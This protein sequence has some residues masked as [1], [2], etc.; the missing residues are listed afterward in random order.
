MRY[1]EILELIAQSN[2]EDWNRIADAPLFL[3][4]FPDEQGDWTHHSERA[5]Y[6][7]DLSVGLAWGLTYREDF[8][9]DW[10]NLHPDKRA[11]G[12]WVDVFYNG[13]LVHRDV[14]VVVDGGRVGLPLP[15]RRDDRLVISSWQYRFFK[16]I[17]ELGGGWDFDEYVKR[18]GFEVE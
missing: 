12:E 10:A 13:M 18:S 1:D 5:A 6:K 3:Y 2:P 14:R 9:E 7:P 8:K 15:E 16:L 11:F 4:G 17:Q